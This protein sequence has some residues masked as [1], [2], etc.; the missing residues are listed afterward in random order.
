MIA[1][2][3]TCR[4]PVKEAGV[5]SRT[6]LQ[7]FARVYGQAKAASLLGMGQGSLNKALRVGRDVVVIQ[8][9]DGTFTAEELRSFPVQSAK[10]TNT[11]NR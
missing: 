4:C 5:M 11:G 1:A 3:D 10:R 7:E 6:S 9:A 8:H 2:G